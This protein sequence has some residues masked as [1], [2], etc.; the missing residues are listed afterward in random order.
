MFNVALTVAACLRAGTRVDVA[1]VI[2]SDT[3][4]AVPAI[5]AL[6]L[7]PGGG[8]TGELLGGLVDGHLT[9]VAQL[10]RPVG[11]LLDLEVSDLQAAA[12]GHP[13]GGQVRCALTPASALP[14]DLWPLLLARETVGLITQLEGDELG[15]SQVVT[16]ADLATDERVAELVRH[17]GPTAAVVGDALVT[18][19][20]PVPQLV[21]SGSGAIAD[22]LA[23]AAGLLGWQVTV[24]ADVGT[25]NGLMARLSS[26][27]SAVVMGHD[28]ESSSRVL[29][30][31]LH[32][33]AGYIGALGSLEMQQRRADWLAYRG[34][35]DLSRVH[36]PAGLDIAA[37]GP[38]EIAVSILAEAIAVHR[39]AG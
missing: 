4:S 11:R 35:E 15:A 22:A 2:A 38:G 31:A 6:A 28:V 34:V 25:A 23:A 18:L 13:S 9:E 8:R 37:Q 27:D 19:F 14:D 26:L 33:A 17:G 5:D 1:W 3:W 7:T 24:A 29:E 12:A 21:V 39:A 32:S 16:G 36:G 20:R 10:Q 30:A